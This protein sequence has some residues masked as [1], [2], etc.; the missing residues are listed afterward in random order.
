LGYALKNLESRTSFSPVANKFDGLTRSQFK[1]IFSEGNL[2]RDH[3]VRILEMPWKEDDW[4]TFAGIFAI[5]NIKTAHQQVDAYAAQE[6]LR[7]RKYA[8]LAEEL[9][10]AINQCAASTVNR[11]CYIVAPATNATP[12]ECRFRF[13]F[14]PVATDHRETSQARVFE[15]WPTSAQLKDPVVEHQL[16]TEAFDRVSESLR[17]KLESE[18]GEIVTQDLLDIEYIETHY[19]VSLAEFMCVLCYLKHVSKEF[20][21]EPWFGSSVAIKKQR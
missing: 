9:M 7:Y 10:A 1:F 20:L 18:S 19:R 2:L 14:K 12:I 21:I 13:V 8:N 4:K 11:Y 17:N 6:K 3:S 15:A 5:E 16:S